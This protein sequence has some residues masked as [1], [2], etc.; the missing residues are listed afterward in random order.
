MTD[1]TTYTY[2]YKT[3]DK[4]SDTVEIPDYAIGVTVDYFGDFAV[5]QYLV[6]VE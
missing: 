1:W 3:F 2:R 4:D 5:V 6:P